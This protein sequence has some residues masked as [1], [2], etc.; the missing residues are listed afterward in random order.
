MCIFSNFL[1]DADVANSK[2]YLE[3]TTVHDSHSGVLYNLVFE[4]SRE[5]EPLGYTEIQ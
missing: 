5:T 2:P 3:D 4:F 1:G